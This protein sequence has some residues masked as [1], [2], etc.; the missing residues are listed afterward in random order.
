MRQKN[1]KTDEQISIIVT[2]MAAS[3][4]EI[5]EFVTKV[6]NQIGG[7]LEE[8]EELVPEYGIDGT[9]ILY[10]C[11]YG[12]R[13]FVKIARG[14]K[15]WVIDNEKDDLDR[16]LF[17]FNKFWKTLFSLSAAWLS[18]EFLGFEL[19]AVSL[20]VLLLCKNTT[21]SGHLF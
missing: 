19:T 12:T 11:E 7:T 8:D 2:L 15:A 9:G 20:L 3:R 4:T 14:Q 5:K 17:T 1:T 13:A 6:I 10:C 21:N 16:M 18:C